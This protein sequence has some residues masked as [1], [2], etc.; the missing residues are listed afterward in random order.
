MSEVISIPL[1][2]LMRSK[3]NVRKTGG[4]SI[5]DLSSVSP[6]D[7]DIRPIPVVISRL[8]VQFFTNGGATPRMRNRERIG[9]IRPIS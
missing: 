5:E 3:H 9:G 2:K 1:N 4:E 7:P 8:S 6:V